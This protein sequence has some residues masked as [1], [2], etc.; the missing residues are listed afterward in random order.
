MRSSG[1][2][3]MSATTSAATAV[4]CAR[5]IARYRPDHT[6]ALHR[7]R[8]WPALMGIDD[9]ETIDPD[10]LWSRAAGPSS[11]RVPIG[12]AEDGSVVE[13]DIKESAEN[14][15]GPHGLCIGATG[16]GKSEFLRTLVLSMVTTHSPDLLNLVLVDFKGGATF[17]G[18]AE[19]GSGDPDPASHLLPED[20][21]W[22]QV[23]LTIPVEGGHC[24]LGTWQGIYLWEHRRI[25]HRRK[26]VVTV[27]GE[28][29]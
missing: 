3:S 17:A 20:G 15:M 7:A 28:D 22:A 9:P 19:A 27:V 23:S 2:P 5:R 10:Q 1:S 6:S 26:L 16:S 29:G 4:A 24:L 13:L 11:L 12:V 25:P 14:G 18:M 8:D 21:S